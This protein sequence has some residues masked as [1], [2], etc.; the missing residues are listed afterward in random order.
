[1]STNSRGGI[2]YGEPQ[3]TLVNLLRLP[4]ALGDPDFAVR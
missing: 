1:M 2:K 4:A 3:L